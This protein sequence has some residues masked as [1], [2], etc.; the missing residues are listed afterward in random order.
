M[1]LARNSLKSRLVFALVAWGIFTVIGGSV[2]KAQDNL[3]VGV[4]NIERLS[5]TANRGFPELQGANKLSPRNAADLERM[6]IYIRDELKVDALMVTE[7]DADAPESTEQRP[8]SAQLNKVV[9]KMG[10]N[11]KYFLSRSG[12]DM[13]LGLLFNSDR[14]KLKKTGEFE[15]PRVFGE[16]QR[17]IG[18]RSFYCMD[19]PERHRWR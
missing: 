18:S 13:R 15:C 14:V 10:D 7:V 5:A 4:W 19:C 16:W 1:S 17:C 9:E 11:W 3:R 8:Q 2:A 12:E 6:A